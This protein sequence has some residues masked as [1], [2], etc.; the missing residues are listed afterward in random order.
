[1]IGSCF[2]SCCSCCSSSSWIT[3][4]TTILIIDVSAQDL[5]LLLIIEVLIREPSLHS[6][7]SDFLLCKWNFFF[8]YGLF[9]L[10]SSFTFKWVF[11]E[12]H[13]I[14][15]DSQ[16]PNIDL[17]ITLCVS[18]QKLRGH[19][20]NAAHIVSLGNRTTIRAKYSEISYFNMNFWRCSRRS[21]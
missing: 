18:L 20:F 4:T 12:Y 17:G 9:Y 8:Y 15:Q 11:A 10:F 21:R 7:K 6:L 3:T 1:M 19:I 5:L 14:H 16:R 2:T 13:C